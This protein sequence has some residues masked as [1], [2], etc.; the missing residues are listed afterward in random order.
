LAGEDLDAEALN[1]VSEST[2]LRDVYN[3]RWWNPQMK[4]CYF[5]MY[6]YSGSKIKKGDQLIFSYGQRGNAYLIEK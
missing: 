6:N 5:T 3:N 1:T 2:R 4:D